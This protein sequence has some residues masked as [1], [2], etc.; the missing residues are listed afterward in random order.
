[1]FANVTIS[2][3]DFRLK[4]TK[5]PNGT[6]RMCVIVR[7]PINFKECAARFSGS[8]AVKRVFWEVN[9]APLLQILANAAGILGGW[10]S[11]KFGIIDRANKRWLQYTLCVAGIAIYAPSYSMALETKGASKNIMVLF[12]SV[13]NHFPREYAHFV[14]IENTEGMI[15][16]EGI[17]FIIM[18][19][20]SIPGLAHST[21]MCTCC[22]TGVPPSSGIDG[23]GFGRGWIKSPAMIADQNISADVLTTASTMTLQTI[24][25]SVLPYMSQ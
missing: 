15:W 8:H 18:M 7:A 3:V 14:G 12:Q 24:P 4:T 19:A 6:V 21:E 13:L 25:V 1:M 10:T 20:K 2:R 5:V 17:V 16:W 9:Q 11:M 23:W 22:F